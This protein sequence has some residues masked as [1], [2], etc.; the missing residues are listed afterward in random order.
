LGV[1]LPKKIC[2]I[3]FDEKNHM[4]TFQQPALYVI[5]ISFLIQDGKYVIGQS[6]NLGSKCVPQNAIFI[7]TYWTT[8]Q[9]KRCVNDICLAEEYMFI[10]LIKSKNKKI[11]VH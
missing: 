4:F 9:I 11:M 3:F 5:D 10:S 8:F 7:E 1:G 6:F 2:I